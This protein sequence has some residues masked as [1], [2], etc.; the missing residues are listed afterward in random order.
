MI[1]IN[2]SQD[3][4]LDN[5]PKEAINDLK[6]SGLSYEMIKESNILPATKNNL[7]KF[8]IHWWDKNK[9]QKRFDALYIIP[10]LFTIYDEGLMCRVK[11]KPLPEYKEFEGKYTQPPKHVLRSSCHLYILPSEIEKLK[12]PKCSLAIV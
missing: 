4:I 9:R 12:S 10:Y 6:N 5:L 7:E 8:K 2:L 1:N 11:V 3:D